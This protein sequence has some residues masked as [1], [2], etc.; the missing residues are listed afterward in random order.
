[1]V[2]NTKRGRSATHRGVIRPLR[3]KP[4]LADAVTRDGT[5]PSAVQPPATVLPSVAIPRASRVG[6]SRSSRKSPGPTPDGAPPPLL[7]PPP[8]PGAFSRLPPP[9]GV[10]ATSPQPPQPHRG[11]LLFFVAVATAMFGLVWMGA[12]QVLQRQKAAWPDHPSEWDPRL[13]ELAYFV[14]ADR[15]QDFRFPVYLDV[16]TPEQMS[17]TVRSGPTGSDAEARQ[18]AATRASELRALGLFSGDAASPLDAVSSLEVAGSRGEDELPQ[19]Y[20]DAAAKRIV[21]LAPP[22][23]GDP[24]LEWNASVVRALTYALRDQYTGLAAGAAEAP[25]PSVFHA[26]AEGEARRT[27]RRFRMEQSGGDAPSSLTRIASEDELRAS[28]SIVGLT[29]DLLAEPMVETII[30]LDGPKAVDRAFSYPPLSEEALFDPS[31]YRGSGAVLPVAMPDPE[32]GSVV[33]REGTLGPVTWY[34][35]LAQVTDAGTA[36][37]AAY[38]WGGDRVVVTRYGEATCVRLAFRGDRAAD[39]TEMR[40]ALEAWVAAVAGARREVTLVGDQLV[41]IGCDPGVAAPSP[42]HSAARGTVLGPRLAMETV[43][44]LHR[45]HGLTYQRAR[46]AALD[47]VGQHSPEELEALAEATATQGAVALGTTSLQDQRL[48]L[49][50]S[51]CP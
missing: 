19:S 28:M 1:M 10:L 51:R 48:S 30:D 50:V 34:V 38:G 21:V 27:E 46:C 39:L 44:V 24:G 45:D 4:P 36:L 20:Y 3:P 47:F 43:R 5:D 31:H 22:E 18:I 41:V 40:T 33:L 15:G 42:L 23:Q 6:R 49:A 9:P 14:E 13:S 35:M 7:L 37:R 17:R 29:A 32:P 8:E 2:T 12:S 25:A 11:R 16:L 26:L